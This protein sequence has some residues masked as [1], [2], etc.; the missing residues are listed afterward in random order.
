MDGLIEGILDSF[1]IYRGKDSNSRD[2]TDVTAYKNQVSPFMEKVNLIPVQDFIN[3][4]SILKDLSKHKI[5]ITEM[6]TTYPNTLSLFLVL[7]D[8]IVEEEK[9][10]DQ[11]LGQLLKLTLDNRTTILI[12]ITT[13]ISSLYNSETFHLFEGEFIYFM[14]LKSTYLERYCEGLE[15]IAFHV[16]RGLEQTKVGKKTSEIQKTKNQFQ[17]LN[18]PLMVSGSRKN[19]DFFGKTVKLNQDLDDV[20]TRLLDNMASYFIWKKTE[21]STFESQY[22]D[23]V[24]K[25]EL[26]NHYL[27]TSLD[28]LKKYSDMGRCVSKDHNLLEGLML[29]LNQNLEFVETVYL[30]NM[31]NS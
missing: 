17:D 3:I 15:K 20:I 1:A 5:V 27:K 24:S 22:S 14:Q 11:V 18:Q 6:Q 19:Y 10:I 8:E 21:L 28:T 16:I 26:N 2:T 12:L 7:V 13:G 23:L 25:T 29:Q 30:K 31:V 4:F 9:E